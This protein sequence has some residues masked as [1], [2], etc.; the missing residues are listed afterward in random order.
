ME[1]TLIIFKPDCMQ[2]RLV[3]RIYSRFEDKGFQVVALK[4]MQITP[5]LAKQH[6]AEHTHKGW[7][8]S[9]E[10]FMTA[11]PVI[12]G[13]LEGP[14]VIDVV[15]TMLGKTN[16]REALPG[17]IRGDFSHS[18][19][20]NLVHASADSEAA[21]REIELFFRMSE[22]LPCSQTITPWLR[23]NDEV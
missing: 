15:R 12:V 11:C 9:L 14:G 16:G 20:M 8:P 18:R 3:G 5:D 6:Y 23:A 10:G 22:I 7:Y 21:Q 2:R 1:R 4:L 19:Q 13:I 17:T